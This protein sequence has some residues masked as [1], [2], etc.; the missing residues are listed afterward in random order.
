MSQEDIQSNK[1]VFISYSHADLEASMILRSALE[2]AG[3]IIFKDEDIRKGDRWVTRLEEALQNCCAFVLL[4]GREGVQ[5]WIGAEVQIALIR[6]L[7]PHDDALRLPIFPVLLE[8]GD[9]RIPATISRV[10]PS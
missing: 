1:Q 5:R 2:Q 3:L 10:I 8:E 4:V 9:G 7:S 6:H